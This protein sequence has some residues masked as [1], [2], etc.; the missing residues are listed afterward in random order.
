MPAVCLGFVELAVCLGFGVYGIT[1]FFENVVW[2]DD[3]PPEFE[4]NAI[5]FSIQAFILLLSFITYGCIHLHDTRTK[6][7][8][9]IRLLSSCDCTRS[10]PSYRVNIY[11][12]AM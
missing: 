11:I 4:P 9:V 3:S 1:E 8:F 2:S 10:L 12:E 5:Q 7:N 6:P